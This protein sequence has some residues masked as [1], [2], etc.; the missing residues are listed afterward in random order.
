MTTRIAPPVSGK[1]IPSVG[2]WIT[3]AEVALVTDAARNGW[4]TN[5]SVYLT[6]FTEALRAHSGMQH[7]LPLS[8]CTAAIHVAMQGLGVGPGDEV[9]V[10][11]LTWV[12]SASPAAQLGATPVFADVERDSW[13]LSPESFERNITKRTKAVVVVGLYGNMPKMREIL[14]IA[15]RKRVAVIED[16]AESIGALYDGKPAGC[17]GRVG[18]YS[19]NATKMVVAGQGGA[20][21][22]N[23][24]KLFKRIARLAHH[25]IDKSPGARYYWSNELG[26]NYNWTNIQAAL[27]LAQLRRI[28]EL[29]ERKR[30][31]FRWYQERLG[32]VEAVALNTEA[33]GVRNTYWLVNAIVDPKLKIPKERIQEELK[34]RGIDARPFFYPISSMPPYRQYV[35]GRKIRSENKVTY[36]ISPYGINLPCAFN[37]SEDD[38]DHVCD[39]LRQVLRV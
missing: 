39:T 35:R 21:V 32:D 19:F 31:I 10:P 6:Q 4:Y 28:E 13:C 14:E 12:A 24:E 27:C 30:Q 16:A 5:M 25:G 33:P 37:I 36:T 22:T 18:V 29:V 26:Y 23:D 11:D 8:H 17:F 20:V 38:V 9:I 7:C 15:Q 2:P 34:Q 1:R 3:E